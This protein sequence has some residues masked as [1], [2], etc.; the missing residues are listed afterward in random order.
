MT[1]LGVCGV[2]G[3]TRLENALV[4]F[5]F[6]LGL[7]WLG[8]I[9]YLFVFLLVYEFVKRFLTTNTKYAGISV[10]VL[11]FITVLVGAWNARDYK[12]RRIDIP[13]D[14][15]TQEVTLFHVPDIHLGPFRGKSSLQQ[16]VSDIERL[17]PDLVLINGDLI[18]GREGMKPNTLK[19][20]AQVK[21]PMYFTGGNH[22]AYVGIEKVR[23]LITQYGVRVLNNEI[24]ETH[25]IQLVGLD[26]MNADSD[27]Y[28]VHASER[29]ETIK[30]VMP[31]LGIDPEVPSVI[32]HHSPA[33]I[34]YM[35]EAGAD[36]VLSG[37]THGGQIFPATLI[38]KIQFPYL[39]GLYRYESTVVYVTQGI[40]T[41]GPPIRI[42]TE[43]EATLIKL[44]RTAE[45]GD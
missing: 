22:D 11:S 39:K 42:G 40:G 26:Y 5:L 12:V 41:F 9:F 27:V 15:L 38:A 43:G 4:L 1:V 18:D 16:I 7:V 20:L 45:K 24:V 10:I 28:D 6:K 29:K 34:E 36:L 30:S 19:L 32:M 33:G 13:I 17:N 25:G 3:V 35:H 14:G 8:L 2:V 44:I 21:K 37:H 23:E 31:I